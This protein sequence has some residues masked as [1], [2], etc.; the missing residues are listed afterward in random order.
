[1]KSSSAIPWEAVGASPDE[2][3]ERWYALRLRSNFEAKTTAILKERGFDGFSPTYKTRRRWSDRV[4]EIDSPL[5]P[6]YVFCRFGAPDLLSI[7]NTP[8]VVHIVSIGRTPVPI[9][10]AEI[11]SV[12]AI[13]S[14][15]LTTHPWA[16]ASG[17]RIV[18]I[19]GP[20]KGAEGVVIKVKDC[21]RIVASI[22]LL[23]R[24]VSA[25]LEAT[26]VTPAN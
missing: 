7:L 21:Y 11:A 24:A 15:N 10:D 12:K 26:W 20:L 23:Q 3:E 13:C 22:S 14:S 19:D 17:R 1:M 16:V 6:G 2:L 8:G 5:F 25:E 9:D 4:K 18:I